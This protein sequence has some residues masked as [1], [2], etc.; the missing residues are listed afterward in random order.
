MFGLK[1]IRCAIEIAY[2]LW[3]FIN[4]KLWYLTLKDQIATPMTMKRDFLNYL[5]FVIQI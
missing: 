4:I 3:F 1:S 2:F 5:V